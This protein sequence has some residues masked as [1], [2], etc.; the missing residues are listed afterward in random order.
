MP[1]KGA[2]GVDALLRCEQLG[3]RY[4]SRWALS[5][6]SWSVGEG[7]HALLGPNGA[8]KSSLMSVLSTSR[9]PDA[10]SWSFAGLSGEDVTG[11]RRIMGYL[12]QD[13]RFYPRL[14]VLENLQYFAWMRQIPSS[15]TASSISRALELCGLHERADDSVRSL[16]GGMRRRL[17]IAQAILARPQL[18]VLDEPTAGLDIAQRIALARTVRELATE[19]A[20]VI[21]ST[22]L[23]DD[24]ERSA[25]SVLLLR[26]GHVVHAGDVASMTGSGESFEDAYVRLIG[27]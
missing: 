16:S 21:M 1:E 10:G 8:G 25:D 9:R 22:H 15:V 7:V 27:A 2:S 23:P 18:V 6:F 19:G 11:M 14:S 4:R 17:G 26:Q 24:V 20:C 12:P 13:I 5:G 3:V